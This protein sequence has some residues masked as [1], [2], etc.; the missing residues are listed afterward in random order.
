MVYGLSG[1][2]RVEGREGREKR[3]VFRF[4]F[5][6]KLIYLFFCFSN[7]GIWK[8]VFIKGIVG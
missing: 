7:V 5:F 3:N 4:G 8:K 2:G 6:I 1:K